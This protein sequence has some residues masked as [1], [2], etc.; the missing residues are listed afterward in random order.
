MQ[1]SFFPK[2]RP[3]GKFIGSIIDYGAYVMVM[4][5]RDGCV[6][7]TTKEHSLFTYMAV[8]RKSR[9]DAPSFA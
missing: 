8:F 4:V 2:G 6:I 1:L 7:V 9:D 5:V 3:L